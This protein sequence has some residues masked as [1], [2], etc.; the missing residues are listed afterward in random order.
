LD[1]ALAQARALWAPVELE[2]A[3]FLAH[4][5]D[6]LPEGPSVLERLAGMHLGDLF[7]ACA[8]T[9]ADES[10]LRLLDER[11]WADT[12]QAIRRLISSS[13]T[14]LDVEQR[15]RARLF[16]R[17][18]DRAARISDYIGRGPLAGWLRAAGVREALVELRSQRQAAPLEDSDVLRVIPQADE[19][20]EE[21]AIRAQFERE[22]RG[23]FASAVAS[24]PQRERNC[25]RLHLVG[26]ASIEQIGQSYSVHRATVARW[27]ASAR[28]RLLAA[29]RACLLRKLNVD[30]TMLDSLFRGV[31]GELDVS[32]QRLLVQQSR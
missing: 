18:P 30:E 27:I 16:I 26:G 19:S 32:F 2:T 14:V 15:L 23:C 28:E 10:A 3:V 11:L 6:R 22:F 12:H 9:E 8:C 24:L 1:H 20:P 31:E 25:L 17:A 7:L 29:T 4:V 5:A 21:A 13:A